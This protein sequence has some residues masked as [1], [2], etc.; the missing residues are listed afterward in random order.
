MKHYAGLDVSLNEVS[1]CVVDAEGAVIAEGKV[2][3][4]PRLILSWIADRVGAVERIVHE[5]GPLSV[6]LTRE[7]LRLGAPVVC[8]DARAAHKALSARMNKSDRADAEALA[9]LARTGWYREVHIKSEA[10]HRLRL[11]LG[12]RERMNRIR[13]DIEA[14]ARGVLKTFGIR[15]GSVTRSDNRASFR[16]Q[17]RAAASGDP[18]LETIAA[19]LIAVHDVACTEAAAIEDELLAIAR[20]SELARRLMTVPGVGPIVALSFIAAIDDADRFAKATDVGAYLGLTPRRYQSGAIDYSGRISKRGDGA[21]RSLLYEAANVLITRV[22]RFSPLKAWAV[23]LAARKGFKKAAVATARKIA[24]V[25]LC[26][27]RDGTT[28]AWTK[29]ALP[30]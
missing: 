13:Q 3:T 25:M 8:I 23:R 7:L 10:S 29:E 16:D 19:S 26:L 11:L 21:T 9:Q 22:R 2:A 15:L 4:E 28:F 24:V 17:L 5:S 30:A 6:W 1:I 27:W 18:I 12:A 20:E 14:Q